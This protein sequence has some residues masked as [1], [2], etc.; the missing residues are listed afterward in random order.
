MGTYDFDKIIERKGTGALKTDALKARY[1]DADL[2]PLWVA[3]MDFETPQFITEAIRERLEHPLFG[4]TVE[5]ADYRPAIIDWIASHHGW[6]VRP[7]WLSYIPGIVKGIGMA[8]NVFV[9]EDEKIIIQPP[10]Y[11]PFRL[12]AQGN[13]REV[14]NNPL[15]ECADGTYAMDF[16][17]L[18]QI[19][20]DKCRMLILSN[21]HNPAG[22]TWD[23]ETLVRLADFCYR[24]HI[25]VISDEIHSDLALWDNRHIPFATVSPEAAAYMLHIEMLQA[26]VA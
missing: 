20:D 16:E 5:P 13:Q 6:I 10:V 4:Y 26:A 14:V 23:R 7:E 1:G 15:R 19:V 11:H 8:I 12:T 24:H 2:M 3:D 9:K 25:I 22:I 18:D 21:P 17:Q